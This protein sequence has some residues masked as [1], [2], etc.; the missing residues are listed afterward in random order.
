MFYYLAS[1][2]S[3]PDPNIRRERMRIA[4]GIAAEFHAARITVYSPVVHGHILHATGILPADDS[5]WEPH[6]NAMLERSAGLIA[7]DIQRAAAHSN[8]MARERLFAREQ[9]I[10]QYEFDMGKTVHDWLIENDL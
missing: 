3:H 1:P 6:N 7:L 2:Y 9:G 5:F 4:A 8:G 10:P